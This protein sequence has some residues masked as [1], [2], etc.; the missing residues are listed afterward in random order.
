M[1][2]RMFIDDE[3]FP[4]EGDNAVI[5]RSSDEAKAVMEQ[6]GCPTFISFDHDLGG[7]DTSMGIVHWMIRQDLDL[8][9]HGFVFIPFDFKFDVHS[10]NPV[11]AKNI[12]ELLNSYLQFRN[13]EN[14]NLCS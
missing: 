11:G 1:I 9:H 10:Q 7:D 3:R 4:V 6:N 12:T 2:Y 5:V 14:G 8:R 13:S